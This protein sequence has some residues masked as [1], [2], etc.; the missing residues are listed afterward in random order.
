AAPDAAKPVDPDG[1]CH[2]ASPMSADVVQIVC[3]GV[4]KKVN[5]CQGVNG[6]RT[7]FVLLP[8]NVCANIRADG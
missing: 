8:L 2:V 4:Q 1:D 7:V 6:N 5:C 3:H